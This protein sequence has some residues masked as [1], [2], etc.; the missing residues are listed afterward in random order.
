MAFRETKDAMDV[1]DVSV[2]GVLVALSGIFQN[3]A[4]L[5]RE[6]LDS[7]RSLKSVKVKFVS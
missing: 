2:Y 1:E 6:K 3:S 5:T 7:K 4:S